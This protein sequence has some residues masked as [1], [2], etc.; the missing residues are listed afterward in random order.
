MNRNHKAKRGLLKRTLSLL[1]VACMMCGLVLPLT[2]VG[3]HAATAAEHT[4]TGTVISNDY[5]KASANREGRLS[6]YT[7][8]GNPNSNTDNNQRLLFG[9]LGSGSSKTVLNIDGSTKVFSGTPYVTPDGDSLYMKDTYGGVL[10]E[11]YI[12]FSYNTYTARY[13]TIEYKY[14]FTNTSGSVKQAGARIFFDTML[15]S[16][17]SAPFRI[18]G[19]NVTS[20]RSFSGDNVPQVWQVFNSYTNSTVVASGTFYNDISERPDMVQFL[21]YGNGSHEGW[22]CSGSGSIGDSAVNIY[23]NP[24]PL[25]PGE[26]REIKT[27]YGLSQFVPME[28]EEEDPPVNEHVNLN[29]SALAPMELLKNDDGTAYLG[30]PFTFNGGIQ[31]SG[32]IVA[33]NAV[34]VITLPEGLRVDNDTIN[35]GNISAGGNAT[36]FWRITAADRENDATLQYSVTYYADGVEPETAQY[37]IFVPSLRHNH[38]Y[39]EAEQKDPTCDEHGYISYECLCGETKLEII[40]AHGHSLVT[41]VEE[42]VTCTSN[43]LIVDRCVNDGCDYEKRT[44]IHGEHNYSITERQ[45]AACET[46]GYIEYTCA[47]CGEKN[48]EYFEGKHN[49]VESARVEPQVEVEGSITYTCTECGTSY[50]I[51]LPAL[52]PVLKNSAVLLIQDS[53]PWAENVNTSLL[54]LLKERGVVSSY[55]IISTNALASF[56]LSQYGVVMIANDQST[57]MYGRL[58]ANAEKLEN[59]VRAGGNLI[60]GACDQGWGGGGSISHALPGGVTT[61]NYY[62]VHNYIVNGLHPIV[63]GVY[64]DNRSLRDELLKGNYCSHTY[65]NTS[66][67]PE[68]TG[69]LLRDANGNPTLIEYNLGDGTVIASGLTWEYFYVRSHYNMSTNY[70]KYVYD[71]LVTYMVYTSSTCEHSYEVDE[72]VEATCLENGYTK[73]VCSLCSYQYMGDIVFANGHTPGEWI[74]DEAASCL[75]GSQHKNCTECGELVESGEIPPV[76]EHTASEWVVDI[77]PTATQ[78]GR[79]HKGCTVCGAVLETETMPILAMLVIENVEAAAGHTVRVTIDI[80]NNPGIIGAVLTLHYDSALTL[81]GAEAGGAWSTLTFTNPSEFSN[82]CNFVWDGVNNDDFSNGS[83]LVLT[84]E[85]PAGAD[86]DT[87]YNISA[88]YTSGNMI[89]ADLEAVDMEIVDGSITVID[90]EGDVNEDGVV[91]VADVI[92]LRRYLA[93]GYDVVIDTVAAD[94]DNDGSITVADIVLLR[95]FLVR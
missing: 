56:D 92:T 49:Y 80:Q 60:Y 82:P 76:S 41:T 57:A 5:L 45:E 51:A 38:A 54:E 88:S 66:T 20:H 3:A 79:R 78:T 95:R 46:D 70:S 71:D 58:A 15:G 81:V 34:A 65:F 16:N 30:N 28:E 24:K 83:I 61:S 17:D 2:T 25:Q 14:V 44:V 23:F 36:I 7:T 74:E 68:G 84:F 35:L 29:I 86:V 55:N 21:S 47:N 91:D 6:L 72:T 18:S 85:L 31:N 22:D 1:L 8:G 42:Q 27:Y 13:D 10:I 11:C 4:Q 75:P 48:Y 63:T 37:T 87:V 89:N 32:N 77:A 64:T 50:D 9:D 19:E 39:V 40:R 12:S 33:E 90:T 26:S 73:Y 59:Y 94:M 62:S 52:T 67:L 53:L 69:I 43:G 93:G